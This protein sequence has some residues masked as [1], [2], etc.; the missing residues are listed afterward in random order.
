MNIYLGNLSRY[1]TGLDATQTLQQVV[2]DGDLN[3]QLS[4]FLNKGWKLVDVCVDTVA[5][6]KG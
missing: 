4:L 5:M 2:Y 1:K 3:E 6:A